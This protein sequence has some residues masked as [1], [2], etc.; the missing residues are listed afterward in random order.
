MVSSSTTLTD[1][2]KYLIYILLFNLISNAIKYNKE[3]GEVRISHFIKDGDCIIEVEDTGIGIES[4]HLPLIFNRFKRIED[5][6]GE[7]QGLGL[8]I[9]SS[10]ATF[11]DAKIE[12]RSDPGKGSQFRVSLPIKKLN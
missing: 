10:I 12:V 11:H 2:N 9:V 8:S 6:T 1:V 7:G 5:G 3:G 4:E